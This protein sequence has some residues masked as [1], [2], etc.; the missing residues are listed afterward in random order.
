MKR[1]FCFII[2][3]LSLIPVKADTFLNI[4]QKDGTIVRYAFADKPKLTYLEASVAIFTENV[5]VVYPVKELSKV[6]FEEIPTA[7]DEVSDNDEGQSIV[8]DIRGRIVATFSNSDYVSLD[9]LS[10]GTYIVKNNS[11]TYKIYKK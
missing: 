3:L 6:T 11:T 1:I 10:C 5:E 2:C 8:Y 4:H 7:I 9:S